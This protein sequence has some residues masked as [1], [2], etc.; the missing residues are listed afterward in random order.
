V[1]NRAFCAYH[2]AAADEHGPEEVRDGSVP[3]RRGLVV[4]D[5]SEGELAASVSSSLIWSVACQ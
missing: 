2:L 4:E 1:K 3:K 5:V